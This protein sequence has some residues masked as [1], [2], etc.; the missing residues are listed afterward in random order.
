MGQWKFSTVANPEWNKRALS[1]PVTEDG[2]WNNVRILRTSNGFLESLCRRNIVLSARFFLYFYSD[3]A[4]FRLLSTESALP[5][6][7]LRS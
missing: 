1:W 3:V 6:S 7:L 4:K 5:E 2:N